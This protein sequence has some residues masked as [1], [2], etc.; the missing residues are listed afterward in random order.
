V[1]GSKEDRAEL[2]EKFDL[3]REDKWIE[4]MREEKEVVI[5]QEGLSRIGATYIMPIAQRG[6]V[7]ALL[8]ADFT[9]ISSPDCT[10]K[11]TSIRGASVSI[12]KTT[13]L[14]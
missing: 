2:G 6:V 10:T 12:S 11:L 13:T 14:P 8:A 4:A 9:G 5:L 7:R 3:F 1:D